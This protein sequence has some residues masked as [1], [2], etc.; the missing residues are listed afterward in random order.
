MRTRFQRCAP[1]QIVS[2]PADMLGQ[3]PPSPSSLV[4]GWEAKK[5]TPSGW[6]LDL[7]NQMFAAVRHR[8][9]ANVLRSFA[10]CNADPGYSGKMFFFQPIETGLRDLAVSSAGTRG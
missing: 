10:S 2:K 7:S 1:L 5:T 6:P 3:S 8:C 4:V 9:T